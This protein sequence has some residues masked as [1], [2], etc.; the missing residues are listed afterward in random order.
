MADYIIKEIKAPTGYVLDE[1]EQQVG[2]EELKSS[3]AGNATVTKT[4][5]N[6]KENVSTPETRNIT[7][8]KKW[9]QGG[10]TAQ[11]P[12]KVKVYLVE[13][14]EKTNKVQ[15]LSEENGWKA[16]F[17]NLPK[18]DASG[19]EITYTVAEENLQDYKPA[20]AGTQD[21]G[22]TITNYTGGRVAIPVT[23]IWKGSGEHPLGI[24]I[25]LFAD[26]T[27]VSSIYLT[28]E[29]G[30]QHTFDLPKYNAAGKEINYTVTEENV[31][32]YTATRADDE[33]SGYKNVFVN[34]KDKPNN[35][36]GGGNTPNNPG[37]GGNTPKTPSGNTPKDPGTPPP[38]TP[39]E[40]GKVLG[41]SRPMEDNP[42]RKSEVLGE[43]RPAVK[44]RA[45]VA[46]EDQSAMKLYGI[47]FGLSVLSF[48]GSLFYKKFFLKK[49]GN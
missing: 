35:P 32:G 46:T 33:N 39:D 43:S 3:A 45:A 20:I 1:Q 11:K 42:E 17:S 40:P 13:N 5:V 44:G 21:T 37:G 34:T 10:S 2:K 16:S 25:Q 12:E 15:E 19:A 28:A 27:R 31:Y 24:T 29:H 23:K 26:G 9:I 14:G 7:I 38:S 8:D 4:F 30:W 18:K 6:K 47:L 49:R 48:W 22:F 41:A 36:G